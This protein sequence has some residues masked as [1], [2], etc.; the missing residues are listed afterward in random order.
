MVTSRNVR[1]FLGL[2]LVCDGA[3]SACS[4]LLSSARLS[5]SLVGDEFIVSSS[6]AKNNTQMFDKWLFSSDA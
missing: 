6:K 3:Y 4:V 2:C 5:P 1:C